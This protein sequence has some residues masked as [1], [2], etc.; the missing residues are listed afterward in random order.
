MALRDL[1][2][3]APDERTQNINIHSHCKGAL[4]VFCF[5]VMS[6][7]EIRCY[8]HINGQMCRFFPEDI[9]HVLPNF[10]VETEENK[11]F[12][13]SKRIDQMIKFMTP[14]LRDIRFETF[15][16]QNSNQRRVDSW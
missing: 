4:Q 1:H 5:H 7:E 8:M 16:K 2:M 15:Y 11:E 14:K 13:E 10:Y 6:V 3:E 12:I 9:K